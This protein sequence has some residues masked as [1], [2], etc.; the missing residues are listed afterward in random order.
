MNTHASRNAEA[1]TRVL[2]LGQLQHSPTLEADSDICHEAAEYVSPRELASGH[3]DQDV[4][5]HGNKDS[6]TITEN[7][8]GSCASCSQQMSITDLI[9]ASC[10]H[11]Y[12]KACVE[13]F[14]AA[15]LGI[16]DSFPPSCCKTP[17]AFSTVAENVS[18]PL[19]W[20]YRT[21]QEGIQNATALY[22]G[23]PKCGVKIVLDK[24][25]E[26]PYKATCT[27]CHKETCRK[28]R[29]IWPAPP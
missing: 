18:T 5:D 20:R 3:S 2:P 11:R 25:E 23:E 16:H 22:C 28:C 27:L 26:S 7:L 9:K 15:S 6:K 19:F 10:E 21:R 8:E 14:I 4:V 13:S 1:S 17:M 24:D 12:C 29:G